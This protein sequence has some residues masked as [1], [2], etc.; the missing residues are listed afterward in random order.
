[1]GTKLQVT[2][3]GGFIKQLFSLMAFPIDLSFCITKESLTC[4]RYIDSPKNVCDRWRQSDIITLWQILCIDL[5]LKDVLRELCEVNVGYKLM[6]SQIIICVDRVEAFVWQLCRLS[7]KQRYFSDQT[8]EI[9]FH[10]NNDLIL[11][12]SEKILINQLQ[13]K[14]FH[15]RWKEL[16]AC[17]YS[18]QLTN[19]SMLILNFYK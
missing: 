6:M 11:I 13:K 7:P 8:N 18:P 2:N 10:M 4:L 15:N 12:I 5:W 17:I 3:L 1:M 16:F 14:N 19:L 9:L